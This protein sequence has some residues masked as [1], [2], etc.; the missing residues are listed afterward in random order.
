MRTL[1]FHQFGGVGFGEAVFTDPGEFGLE[2]LVGH[3]ARVL[4]FA[5][6]LVGEDMQVTIGDDGFKG[7]ATVVRFAVLG[8]IEPT[9]QVLRTIVQR[10]FDEMVA[11]TEIRLAFAVDKGR[12]LAIEDLTHEDV[13]AILDSTTL[14]YRRN[15]PSPIFICAH[16]RTVFVR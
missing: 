8:V 15:I 11:D 6:T 13:T 10:V 2:V 14:G 16:C 7:A 3:G 4:K 5:Q 9:E 1:V 12:S